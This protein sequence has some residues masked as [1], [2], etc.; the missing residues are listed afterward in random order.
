M[1]NQVRLRPQ[2][3]EHIKNAFKEIFLEGDKLWVFG[4]RADLTARG[5]DIDLYIE[6]QTE[7][8]DTAYSMKKNF[9]KTLQRLLGEQKIDIVILRKNTKPML[10]HEVA[11]STGVRLI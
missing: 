8:F 3:I 11:Q 1:E 9:W 6:T 2:A 7:D 10:I 5:G 4:S